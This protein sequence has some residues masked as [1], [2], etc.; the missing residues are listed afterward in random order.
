MASEV[1]NV[2]SVPINTGEMKKDLQVI[3]KDKLVLRVLACCNEIERERGKYNDAV[4]E[5][6]MWRNNFNTA[7]RMVAE[8]QNKE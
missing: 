3:P 5:I 7:M 1:K 8:Y 4:D 6:K 2:F